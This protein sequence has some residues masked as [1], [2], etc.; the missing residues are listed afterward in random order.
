MTPYYQDDDVTIYH[1]DCRDVLP[2]ISGVA[3]TFTS[4]PYNTLGSRIPS[5][6]SGIWGR[7]G[8][9]RGFVEAVNSEGYPDDL[10]EEQYQAEQ[11]EVGAMLARSTADGGCF[12][13]N[14]KCRWRNGTLL[15]PAIW[16]KPDGWV[17]RADLIWNRG[18]SMTLNARM[19]APSDER[20]LW[21]TRPGQKHTWNQQSGPALL[22]V[23]SIAHESGE[24]KPH[25]VSFPTSLPS[26][27]IAASSNPG[28][29]VLDP[30][31]GSGTTMVAARALGRRSIGIE[32]EERFCKVAV[33]RLS[34][35]MLFGGAGAD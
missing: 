34:Q 29:V 12:Y 21:F 3:M 10:P 7:R 31:C 1:G 16:F 25:P 6:P 15:H 23:W 28:D 32:R 22:S 17:L 19:W 27:A 9:A 35:K 13:Y 8:G 2:K 11:I 14:H 4:P 18:R 20:I 24:G 5:N 30:Y 26:R 33:S